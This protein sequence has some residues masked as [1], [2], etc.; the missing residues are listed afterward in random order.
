MIIIIIVIICKFDSLPQSNQ[1]QQQPHG[2]VCKQ[3]SQQVKSAHVR[4]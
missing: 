3:A 2:F 4:R 1:Q